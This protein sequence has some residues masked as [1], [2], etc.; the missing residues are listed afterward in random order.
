MESPA[1]S[2]WK[3]YSLA[4]RERRW[5]AVRARAAEAGFDCVFV[6]LGNRIDGR[7]LTEMG[8]AVIALPTDGRP[9]IVVNDRGTGNSWVPQALAANRAWSGPMAQALFDLGMER[10]RIGVVGLKAG[11]VSHVRAY[12]GVVNYSSF[13]DVVRR[14]PNA[15]FEDATDVVGFVRYVKSEE[16]IEC[17]RRA[18]AIAEAGVE[19]MIEHARPGVDEAML[20]AR[21]T[22]RMLALGSEQYPLALNIGTLDQEG[23]RM[24][25][26]PLGRRLQAGSYIANEVS[27][28][29]A[30]QVAQEDQPIL[31]GPIP[32]ELQA[33]V[34]LQREVFEAG[35][36]AMKPGTR[37][38]E[39]IDFINGYGESRGMKTLTLMHGRGY[40]D[41]GPLLTP[42]ALG[43]NVRELRIERGNAW[44]WK[45]YGM[46]ADG[47]I[48]F[49]W[50]GDV[51]VTDRGG[52]RLFK[53]PQGC[54][55]IT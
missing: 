19:E 42:R 51:V 4:E 52:E 24:T 10:A 18:T 11:K 22:G 45:P 50:G 2:S 16:E 12:E 13:A 20:Y 39:F 47:R 23:P 41:D 7:Y 44:V 33:V 5:N 21:V 28:V 26:P 1:D 32:T 30:G 29:W 6:P 25:D 15:V 55:S 38:G 53:R 35:L 43:E 49:V 37:F 48:S 46:S 17:L 34:E 9:P 3:G 27:A 40:G 36:E 54:V 14:L 8:N 31:L